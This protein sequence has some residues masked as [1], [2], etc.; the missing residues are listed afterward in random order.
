MNNT[1]AFSGAPLEPGRLG[2]ILVDAGLAD[3]ADELQRTNI[4]A[5]S[6]L[7]GNAD[8]ERA[9]R[10]LGAAIEA[11]ATRPELDAAL[12]AATARFNATP[13]DAGFAEQLRLRAAREA[14]DRS[15][16]ALVQGEDV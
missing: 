13:D 6:F 16:A 11:L 4:L 10:D 8:T 9:L 14:A 2:S 1:E 7:R 5:F 15:L 3:V 12:A